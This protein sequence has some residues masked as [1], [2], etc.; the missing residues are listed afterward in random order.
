MFSIM[1]AVDDDYILVSCAYS[2]T[3]A[4]VYVKTLQS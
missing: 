1:A 3:S 2:K 4:E